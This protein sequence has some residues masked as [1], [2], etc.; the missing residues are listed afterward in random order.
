MV[1]FAV[2][3]VALGLGLAAGAVA[4]LMSPHP[5]ALAL[6]LVAVS[7]ALYLLAAA[8]GALVL[9]LVGPFVWLASLP[10]AWALGRHQHG[11]HWVSPRAAPASTERLPFAHRVVAFTARIQRRPS[12]AWTRAYR[13]FFVLSIVLVGSAL[14]AHLV[15]G[16]PILDG[17]EDGV[18]LALSFVCMFGLGGIS[19][20]FA[21]GLAEEITKWIVSGPGLVAPPDERPEDVESVIRE[22]RRG[23]RVEGV[24][25]LGEGA[26]RSP[27]AGEPCALVRLKGR[28][29][30]HRVDD[31]LAGPF[32]VETAAGRVQVEATDVLAPLPMTPARP[33]AARARRADEVRFEDERWLDARGLSSDELHLEERTVRDGERVIVWGDAEEATLS[34]GYRGATATRVVALRD[35]EGP[36]LVELASGD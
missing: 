19:L 31:L 3:L 12:D 23:T 17:A 4:G 14:L 1:L 18:S 11:G 36:V 20:A 2:L 21:G 29:G 9:L 13:W 6:G 8:L 22:A 32:V 28:A 15:R 34:D 35:R 5:L 24:V 33:S 26:L 10:V 16:V 25:R 27:L 30:D 7:A